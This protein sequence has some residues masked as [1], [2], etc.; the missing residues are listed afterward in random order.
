MDS[1][2]PRKIGID[3]K[4][5]LFY[6]ILIP[7]VFNLGSSRPSVDRALSALGCFFEGRISRFNNAGRNVNPAIMHVANPA[8]IT[9]PRL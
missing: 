2:Y 4:N 5:H 9:S 7:E 3:I 8:D 6:T 1:F